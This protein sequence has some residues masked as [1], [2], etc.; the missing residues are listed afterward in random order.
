[1]CYH[2]VWEIDNVSVL[3]EPVAS[4]LRVQGHSHFQ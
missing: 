3:E 4:I 1:M 2:V